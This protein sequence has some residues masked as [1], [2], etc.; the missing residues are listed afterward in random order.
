VG[1]N[2]NI[3]MA[4]KLSETESSERSRRRWEEV[5]EIFEVLIL[6]VI[7]V[8]TAWSGYQAARWDGH[9]AVLYGQATKYR[10]EA[11]EASTLGG[12][13]LAA[14]SAMLNS[15]ILAETSGKSKIAEFYVRR[16][17]PDYRAAFE[18]WLVTDP[19]NNKSAPPGPGYM[20]DY[21]NPD[22][23]EAAH[24]NEVAA[25]KFEEGTAAR[26]TAE[27]YVRATVM[28]AAVLFLIAISQRFRIR[29]VRIASLTM[30]FVF[31]ALALFSVAVLPR[32]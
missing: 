23:E 14:D 12:Q 9:Q 32:A 1:E 15:W 3:E 27:K 8:A 20:P 5:A 4:H 17:T 31:L 21:R 19:L 29:A 26:E 7:A 24:L 28:F 18:L 6:A 11:E 13:K 10:F 25:G 16:F 22:L 2:A 30:T